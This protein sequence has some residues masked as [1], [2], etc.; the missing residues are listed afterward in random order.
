MGAGSFDAME[1]NEVLGVGASSNNQE[2]KIGAM[3]Q[4]QPRPMIVDVLPGW[5]NDSF[6]GNIALV[7]EYQE[8]SGGKQALST[9]ISS[10]GGR[11]WKGWRRR[12]HIGDF[13]HLQYE[14]I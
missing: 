2:G 7:A 3:H 4:N 5:S 6:A 11:G 8:G 10:A 9:Y 14:T 1:T 13:Q 12:L